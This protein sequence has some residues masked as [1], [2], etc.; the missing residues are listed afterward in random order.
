MCVLCLGDSTQMLKLS[1]SCKFITAKGE[2]YKNDFSC[3]N[4]MEGP[5]LDVKVTCVSSTV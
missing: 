1:T 4:E 2:L 3:G 5:T